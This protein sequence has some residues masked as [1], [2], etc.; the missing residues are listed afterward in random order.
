M[1]QVRV[2]VVGHG[3][4]GARFVDD[5]HQRDRAGRFRT[6]VLGAEEYE[7]YNRV[8]LSEV[9]A[10]KLDVA[11]ITLPRGAHRTAS[12]VLPGTRA[13]TVDRFARVVHDDAGE[14]HPYDVLVLATGARARVP[15]LFGRRDDDGLPAGV[16]ALRTLDDAR[17]IVAATVNA[18]RAVVVGGGVLGLEVACG[19]AHR[20]VPVTVVH[21]GAH[22]MDRQLDGPAAEVATA[23]LTSLGVAVRVRARTEE[24]LVRDG[25]VTGV[26]LEGGEVLPTDLLVL[27]AGTYPEVGLAQ[28]AGLDV[29][30]GIVV[31]ADLASPA[32]PR[33]FAIGDCAEP[34]EGGSGLIAQGW[35]QARRLA[36]L[37][38]EPAAARDEAPLPTVGTDVVKVKGVGLDVVAMGVCGPRA[39]GR[40]VRLSDPDGGRHI[41]VVVD[42]GRVVGATCVGAGPVAAD[43]VAAYTRGTPAPADPA[44]LLVR[45][46]AGVAVPAASPTMM[47]DRAVVCRCNGVTKGDIVG[48]WRHGARSA[49]DVAAETRATTGC[50]GC[51]DAVCGIVD[52]LRRS[53]PDQPAPVSEKAAAPTMS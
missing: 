29:A 41:E 4:V 20:G 9:V 15:D 5:L 49:A 37:L 2:V 35:D 27:T 8:L 12:E 3:M 48:C 43:L 33:V 1:S 44:Q 32:D 52:W 23:R 16:H 50:G 11:S 53:D 51:A 6:L 7:P 38:T 39:G 28:R 25:R 42:D 17:E 21:G 18:T 19:L 26:R 36:T 31:G 45:P 40:R 30:R 47:P 34:P 46:V 24:A 10:G 22:L 13:V 14:R